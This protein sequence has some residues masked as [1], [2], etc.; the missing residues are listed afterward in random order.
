[1]PLWNIYHPPT[2]FTTPESK[3]SLAASITSVYTAIPLPAF[4]VV[5]Q[6]IPLPPT[7]FYIGAT[8]R[9]SPS[10]SSPSPG[11]DP[12]RP[13]I[14]ITISN[15]ARKIPSKEV[16]DRFLGMVDEAL[17]PHI[18]DKGY[19]WEYSV[20]ETS[21]DLWKINGLVPPMPGSV[22]ERRWV[23]ENVVSEFERGEGGLE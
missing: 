20:E 3:Q 14:R 17:K 1:M 22:A 5:V 16:G 2:T 9:P 6:F 23:E 19:D 11:P 21:R 10:S 18:E 4:Y 8:P 13:F 12:T 15:V 7:S